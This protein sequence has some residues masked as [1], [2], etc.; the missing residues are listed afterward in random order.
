MVFLVLVE[1][2]EQKDMLPVM[3]EPLPPKALG[4]RQF[5]EECNICPP[6]PMVRTDPT[7][8]VNFSGARLMQFASGAAALLQSCIL[9]FGL[10]QNRDIGVGV[11]PEC[12][13]F[14]IGGEGADAGGVALRC[15]ALLCLSR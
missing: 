7:A 2:Y 6:I 15:G 3:Y 4:I 9:G 8:F 5:I 10:F 13:E 12:E 1:R 14:F 11:L